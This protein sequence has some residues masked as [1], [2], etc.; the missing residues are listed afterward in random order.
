[1]YRG[2]LRFFYSK[3]RICF[4]KIRVVGKWPERVQIKQVWPRGWSLPE[5]REDRVHTCYF[6]YFSIFRLHLKFSII[7]RETGEFHDGLQRAF[8]AFTV[9]A[10][11]QPRSGNWGPV[12]RQ[13]SHNKTEHHT[14]A[15]DLRPIWQI[16]TQLPGFQASS[17]HG[18]GNHHSSP[19]SAFL[20]KHWV[21]QHPRFP[22]SF[23]CSWI[24]ES[25]LLPP[26]SFLFSS[27]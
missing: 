18:Q 22:P 24:T 7:K 14:L 3:T 26:G 6:L 25:G 16:Q 12:I 10:W 21:S 2:I 23:V 13:H 8:Q 17:V 4:K 1:M 20:S 9:V 5:S 15:Q 19:D 11:V 27:T